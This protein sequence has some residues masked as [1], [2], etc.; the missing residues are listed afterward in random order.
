MILD[1]TV[2]NDA[3]RGNHGAIERLV[4]LRDAETPVALSSLTVFEVGV[5][6]RGAATQYRERFEEQVSALV[7]L[8]VGEAE[9]RQAVSIQ[10]DLLDRGERIG[11]RDVLIAATAVRSADPRILT[12]NVDEFERVDELD[13]ETY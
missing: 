2:V 7:V 1:S 8:A 3:I 6:L 5:G 10:H 11:A 4:E 9:A 13:V 12:R